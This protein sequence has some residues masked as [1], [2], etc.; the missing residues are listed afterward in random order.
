LVARPGKQMKEIMMKHLPY[1][2]CNLKPIKKID[3]KPFI[4]FKNTF[5][6]G[7]QIKLGTNP[8]ALIDPQVKQVYLIP[9]EHFFT[10]N[11]YFMGP[12]N[13]H[14]APE[15]RYIEFPERVGSFPLITIKMED[16]LQQLPPPDSEEVLPSHN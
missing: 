7:L 15:F 8:L 1:T 10:T 11:Y 16:I 6:E 9:F 4:Y 2:L 3:E 14:I 5:E 13:P 12:T